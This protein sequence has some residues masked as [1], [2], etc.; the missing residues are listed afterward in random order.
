MPQK[1]S[2]EPVKP[3]EDNARKP[4]SMRR[5]EK[6]RVSMQ[7]VKKVSM[8][9]HARQDTPVDSPKTKSRRNI[10]APNSDID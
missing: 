9:H 8:H 4:V 5:S 6:P 3:Q 10:V 2:V 7:P 1:A